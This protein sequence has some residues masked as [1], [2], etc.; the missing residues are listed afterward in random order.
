[1]LRFIN[2]CVLCVICAMTATFDVAARAITQGEATEVALEFFKQHGIPIDRKSGMQRL[3]APSS[4]RVADAYYL[5][6][7]AEGNG[8]V[9]VSGD[10]ALPEIV[11]YSFSGNAG[12]IPPALQALLESY[13][14]YVAD[15]QAGKTVAPEQRQKSGGE[16]YAPLLTTKWNQDKPF[17]NLTPNNYVTGCV[18]TAVAQIMNFHRWPDCGVGTVEYKGERVDISTHYYDWNDMLDEYLWDTG[19][20]HY[21]D[22]QAEAVATLMRDFGYGIDMQ[23]SSGS[24]GA[25]SCKIGHVL[26]EHFK[27]SPSAINVSRELY[28][29]QGWMNLIRS[30]LSNCRPIEYSAVSNVSGSGHSFVCDGIDSSDMLHINWGWGGDYDGYF[31]MDVMAPGGYGIGGSAGGYTLYQAMTIGIRPIQPGEE[32][33]QPKSLLTWEGFR[34][35]IDG[36]KLYLYFDE[37]SNYTGVMKSGRFGVLWDETPMGDQWIDDRLSFSLRDGAIEDMPPGHYLKKD[38]LYDSLGKLTMPGRYH[39]TVVLITDTEGGYEPMLTGDYEIG[40]IVEVDADGNKKFVYTDDVPASLTLVGITLPDD[41]YVGYSSKICYTLRNDGMTPPSWSD[42]RTTLYVIAVPIDVDES[43]LLDWSQYRLPLYGVD[44]SSIYGNSQVDVNTSIEFSSPG[45]YRLH[46]GTNEWV[47]GKSVLRPINEEQEIIIEVKSKPDYPL[48]IVD[49]PLYMTGYTELEA[50]M[51]EWVHSDIG[52]HS[53]GQNYSGA[54]QLWALRDGD[55]ESREIYITSSEEINLGEEPEYVYM[56]GNADLFF[57]EPGEYTAYVKYLDR[58]GIWKRIDNENA[59]IRITVI[60][61][62]KT[63]P[64]LVGPARINGGKSLPLNSCYFPFEISLTAKADFNGTLRFSGFSRENNEPVWNETLENVSI[65]AGENTDIFKMFSSYPSLYS[66]T[67][68]PCVLYVS[69]REQE[70]VEEWFTEM[71]PNGFDDSLYFSLIGGNSMDNQSVVVYEMAANGGNVVEAGGSCSLSFGTWGAYDSDVYLLAVASNSAENWRDFKVGIGEQK[72]HV[73]NTFG[74]EE[75]PLIF[76]EEMPC[77]YYTLSLYY[78][79]DGQTGYHLCGNGTLDIEVVENGN[80]E[81]I[82]SKRNC[83]IVQSMDNAVVVSRFM[84]GSTVELL[85]ISGRVLKSYGCN[86]SSLTI[87][88]ESFSTGVYLI[89]IIQPDGSTQILKTII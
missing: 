40:G 60:P 63:V 13:A 82:Q 48:L 12:D 77:G 72:I 79:L 58:D 87:S 25:Y 38:Y 20:A 5:F 30:E 19:E 85:S 73:S 88:T 80:I 89:K 8:F 84:K 78:R 54:L 22:A 62:S 57:A 53:I 59:S 23:Y 28:S 46:L 34:V 41:V 81:E 17:N 55:D 26:W 24:S 71:H 51:V 50:N 29:R 39:F 15:F 70:D 31:D 65:K 67:G 47:D 2:L 33:M 86:D 14:A 66:S 21:T 44:P 3:K 10:D 61:A 36:N 1:M 64:Y 16:A 42:V 32:G 9:V 56:R 7:P 69:A 52:L 37:L 76:G 6:E 75:I 83:A 43:T 11:G 4:S 68:I 27:Y 45:R 18:A 35:G 49:T 74:Q